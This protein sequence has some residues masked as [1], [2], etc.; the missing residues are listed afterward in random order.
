MWTPHPL[1]M[2]CLTWLAYWRHGITR[3]CKWSAMTLQV[4]LWLDYPKVNKM[5]LKTIGHG[6]ALVVRWSKHGSWPFSMAS[7]ATLLP[8]WM[9]LRPSSYVVPLPCRTSSNL[10]YLCKKQWNVF[11]SARQWLGD[12]T[13]YELGLRWFIFHSTEQLQL[14]LR[15]DHL[16]KTGHNSKT[17]YPN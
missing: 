4:A 10:L 6:W 12:S 16:N 3:D 11:G 8:N 7:H 15:N 17:N 9:Y 1:S 2:K 5:E 13:T 14:V